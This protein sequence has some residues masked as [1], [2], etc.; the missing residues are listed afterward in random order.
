MSVAEDHCLLV[1]KPLFEDPIEAKVAFSDL[2]TW[3]VQKG[4]VATLCGD[5][6][7]SK[8][9]LIA[10]H[11]LLEEETAKHSQPMQCQPTSYSSSPEL[12]ELLTKR[13]DVG[14]KLQTGEAEKT[15][16]QEKQDL[17]G[18]EPSSP[19]RKKPKKQIY[20][21]HEMQL[22]KMDVNGKEVHA[23]WGGQRPTKMDLHFLLEADMLTAVFEELEQD[24]EFCME[25]TKRTY[26][27][28]KS[29]KTFGVPP[30][31]EA[32]ASNSEQSD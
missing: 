3:K 32:E 24:A 7:K 4:P 31:G 5:D 25:A 8:T 12:A 20:K 21:S 10:V 9:M 23:L 2:K 22:I 6:M 17:F 28:K 26:I 1:C 18:G 19:A 13:N 14:Q 11:P 15:E 29:T 30:D 27:K 16:G